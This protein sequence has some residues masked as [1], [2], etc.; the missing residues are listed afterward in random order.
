MLQIN[1]GTNTKG[2]RIDSDRDVLPFPTGGVFGP[3]SK[4]AKKSDATT[5]LD[6]ARSIEQDLDAL[7]AGLHRL[8]VD[9][10]EDESRDVFAAIPFRRF[11]GSG[12]TGPSSPAA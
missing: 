2:S 12:E 4:P 7:Q 11:S 5:G 8:T 3:R 1:T 10:N 6:L 9:I